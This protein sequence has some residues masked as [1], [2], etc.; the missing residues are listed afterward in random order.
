MDD[1]GIEDSAILL[2][3]LGE[4]LAHI[5][6]LVEEGTLVRELDEGISRYRLRDAEAQPQDEPGA[7]HV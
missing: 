3:S 5:N 7:I 4:T 6:F 2:M 1:K